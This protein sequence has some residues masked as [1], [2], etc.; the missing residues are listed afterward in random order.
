VGQ[1]E[2][3]MNLLRRVLQFKVSVGAL[4][5]VALWLAVPYLAVGFFWAMVHAEQTQRIQDRLV[6]VLPAGA[7]VAAFGLTAALWPASI[8]IADACPPK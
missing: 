3:A 2:R 6:D 8:Q 7:D 5:E 4:L 1:I